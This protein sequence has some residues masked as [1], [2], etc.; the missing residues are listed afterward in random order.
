MNAPNVTLNYPLDYSSVDVNVT[1]NCSATDDLGLVNITLYTNISGQWKANE[2][3]NI[4]G[5]SNSTTWLL[6]NIPFGTYKWNCLA[7]DNSGLSGWGENNYT[8]SVTKRGNLSCFVNALSGGQRCPSGYTDVLHMSN[9]TNAHAELPNS[10]LYNYSVC[11]KD[12]RGYFAIYNS[13]G[14]NFLDLSNYTNAHVELPNELNYNF[15][16]WIRAEN[17]SVACTYPK[18]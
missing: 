8:F 3:K 10:S 17:R 5:T 13:S 1:F 9:L 2:T 16:A 4:S 7:Y 14:T 15:E 11:C 18:S 12:L 6:T